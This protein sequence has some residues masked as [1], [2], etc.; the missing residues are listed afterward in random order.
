MACDANIIPAVYGGNSELLDYGRARRT[1]PAGLRRVLNT[2][3]GGCIFPS[4]DRPAS[5]CEAHH[6]VF[7]ETQHGATKDTNL[8]LLRLS[9]EW[10]AF[11][12]FR[13]A[14]GTIRHGC[15]RAFRG[16]GSVAVDAA[17]G[18]GLAA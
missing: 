10:R 5:S 11:G 7:W 9:H 4:C 3:D 12:R 17:V 1:V 18:A 13:V 6:R 15:E 14:R 8:D 2:R 16:F